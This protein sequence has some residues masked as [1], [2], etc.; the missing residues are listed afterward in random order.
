MTGGVGI[1]NVGAGDTKLVFD[2]SNPAECI[3]A[4]RI[5]KDMLRRGYALL[6]ATGTGPDGR[7]TY[8]R[9]IDFNEATAEYIIADFDP[10]V[11]E[12]A[13]MKEVVAKEET[14]GSEPQAAATEDAD[15]SSGEESRPEEPKL[16]RPGRRK[17]VSASSTRAVA[18]PRSAGG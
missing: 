15:T 9:A 18:V 4:A 16:R 11:A 7:P 14:V 5:V 12:A 8:Q 2:P 1:L 13:D 3:R 6:V 10:L 17:T